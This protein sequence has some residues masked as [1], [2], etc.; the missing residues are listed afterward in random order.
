[1]I[2]ELRLLHFLNTPLRWIAKRYGW[3]ESGLTALV[4]VVGAAIIVLKLV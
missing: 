2:L 4:Y 3:S 1:M